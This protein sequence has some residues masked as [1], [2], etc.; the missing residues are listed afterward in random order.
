MAHLQFLTPGGPV[1]LRCKTDEELVDLVVRIRSDF[2]RDGDADFGWQ[3]EEGQI[4]Y[5]FMPATTPLMFE[6]DGEA[7]S[8]LSERINEA[9]ARSSE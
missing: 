8:D 6:F 4:T 2:A 3:L 9:I 5:F 7:P 1:V